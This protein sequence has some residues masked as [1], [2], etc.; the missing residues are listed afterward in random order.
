MSTVIA[1][2]YYAETDVAASL[3]RAWPILLDYRAWNPSF[4]R[5]VVTTVTGESGAQG[6][7]VHILDL[8]ASGTPVNEFYAE[9]TRIVPNRSIAWFVYPLDRESFRNFVDFELVPRDGGVVFQVRYYA[10]VPGDATPE[11]RAE[12]QAAGDAAY[13]DL[14]R[15]FKEY[16]ESH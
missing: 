5:A 11:Q 7:V 12:Q 15:A 10:Q 9:T 13:V 2:I 6:E 3:D 14:A 1:T 8:D 4:A 16:V